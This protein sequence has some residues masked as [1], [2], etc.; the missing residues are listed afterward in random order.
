MVRL[1]R[2][3]ELARSARA[4]QRQVGRLALIAQPCLTIDGRMSAHQE[5]SATGMSLTKARSSTLTSSV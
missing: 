2:M 1:R 4:A 3:T 5:R